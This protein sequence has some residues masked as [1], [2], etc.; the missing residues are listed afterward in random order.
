MGVPGLWD[1]LRPAA[2]RTSLSTL[3]RDAFLVN[4]RGLR[5]L[6][7]GVDASWVIYS[8]PGDYQPDCVRHRIWIF[9]A[10]VPQ[11]G[12]NPFLRTIFYKITSLLQH[13]VLPVFVFDG[14]NK[15]SHK[16]GQAVKGKF[17]TRDTD[18]RKFKELLDVCG[19]EWW[20]APGEAEAELAVM[21]RQ[22][23]IDAVLSDDVD[24]LLFGATC[25]LR[26]NSPTLSGA[27]G[28]STQNN[29]SRSDL[30]HY[31]VFR[32]SAIRK[33][34]AE[35]EGTTLTTEEDCRMAMILVAL[36]AGG[37]YAPEGLTSIG[38]LPTAP[39]S[40]QAHAPSGPTIAHGL[41]QAGL[42]DFLHRYEPDSPLFRAALEATHAKMVQEL[43]ENTSK[44][45]GRRYPDRSSKLAALDPSTVFP[46]FALDAYL[47]P[48]TSP[49]ADPTQGWPGFGLGQAS[50]NRGKARREGRG[51]LEG[52]ARACERYFEWGTREIVG[53]KFAGES[54]GLFNSE[55]MNDARQTLRIKP[56]QAG[57]P[58]SPAPPY[59]AARS[60]GTDRISHFFPSVG[61]S[62]ISA[63]NLHTQAIS[64]TSS[65][66]PAYIVKIRGQR[67]DPTNA[68]L[69]EYRVSYL[70]DEFTVRCHE[71]MDGTRL[72]PAQ[73][74]V[75]KREQLGL[76]DRDEEIAMPSAS[77]AA[78]T[79]S[80]IRAWIPEYLLHQA[81]PDLLQI[82]EDEIRA[83]EAAKEAKANKQ[84]NPAKGRAQSSK[85]PKATTENAAAFKSFFVPSGR[86]SQ[87]TPEEEAEEVET[88]ED[89]S[90]SRNSTPLTKSSSD[91][92]SATT[93][94]RKKS[95]SVPDLTKK[96]RP[97]PD[98]PDSNSASSSRVQ[99][100]PVI[101]ASTTPAG[102]K[103]R[104]SARLSAGKVQTPEQGR[105]ETPIDLCSSDDE[106]PRPLRTRK[107]ATT[108]TPIMTTTTTTTTTVSPA[109]QSKRTAKT[110]PQS[111]EPLAPSKTK[112]NSHLPT[113]RSQHTLDLP[114][115]KTP[116]SLK[117]AKSSKPR[118]KPHYTVIS[119]TEDEEILDLTR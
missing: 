23:K 44:Q 4:R 91:L 41:S 25:L 118:K 99:I 1:L 32:S 67:A 40:G 34:W 70:M 102:S 111:S 84:A 83:K 93:S 11:Y 105:K 72:D 27:Q 60:G 19:L 61:P 39:S 35:K 107:I 33:A 18:S 63:K 13:P 51:D 37:D 106:T 54:V 26:N 115:V 7:I 28:S 82:Y 101:F 76:V 2:S 109:S 119:E 30:R 92:S 90:F 9:H 117:P 21:N 66:V 74:S 97:A 100:Q 95:P 114:V 78:A 45:L 24:A 3:S 16:R 88:V 86:S 68:E 103:P 85:V 12:E 116:S 29:S 6:T 56:V 96:G 43:R 31:E 65:A 20:N 57:R 80:E 98:S 52:M 62:R 87:T 75:D 94:R 113:I 10:Q 49:L 71:A 42:A 64:P 8:S 89:P 53:K 55:V 22:G 47:R 46:D 104:R 38:E 110:K 59:S 48:C 112:T 81:W 50:T 5:A 36:L 108:T 69:Q 58:I 14:P 79:K 77:Q 73:L 17:G 15:P